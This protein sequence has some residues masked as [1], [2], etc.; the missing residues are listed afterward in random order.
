MGIAP[1]RLSEY[2]EKP[3]A[4]RRVMHYPGGGRIVETGISLHRILSRL[5][6]GSVEL[7]IQR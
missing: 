4:C 1:G 3:V 6:N 7:Y 5:R 2:Q